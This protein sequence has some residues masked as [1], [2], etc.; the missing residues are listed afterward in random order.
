MNILNDFG[1]N[2]ILV[3]AQAVNFLIILFILKKFMYKPILEII[4]KREN[5]V[6]EG[7]KNTEEAQKKLEEAIEKEKEILSNAKT[8]AEKII[9]TARD[10]SEEIKAQIEETTKKDTQ[11]LVEQAKETIK[12]ETR[13]TEQRLIGRIGEIAISLLENSL[14]G[15]F[16]KKEQKIILKKALSELGRKDLS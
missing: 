6:S 12:E 13:V 2:P 14:G 10:E 1:V 5:E 7:I 15:I 11:R 4:K 16:G 9:A 8:Q 3:V